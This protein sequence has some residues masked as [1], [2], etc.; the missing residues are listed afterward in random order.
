MSFF[1][2][3]SKD[4]FIMTLQDERYDLLD[5]DNAFLPEEPFVL[6]HGDLHGRNILTKEGRVQ[7]VLN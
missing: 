4:A 1:E 6:V 5:N 2:K 7:A 3:V